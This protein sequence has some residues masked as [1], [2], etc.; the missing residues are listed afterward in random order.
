M[1]T[2]FEIHIYVFLL[3]NYFWCIILELLMNWRSIRNMSVLHDRNSL[4]QGFFSFYFLILW[5]RECKLRWTKKSTFEYI[6]QNSII[7]WAL[8][9]LGKK[10]K[11]NPSIPNF[12]FYLFL[13]PPK[14]NFFIRICINPIPNK[15]FFIAIWTFEKTHIFNTKYF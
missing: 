3:I 11:N 7:F 9:G 5:G 8:Q 14:D 6:T 12:F 1:V 15:Y 10:S 13:T 2:F 4:Q